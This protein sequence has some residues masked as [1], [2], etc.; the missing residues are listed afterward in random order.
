VLEA[1]AGIRVS[2]GFLAGVRGRAATLLETEFL[3]H[4]RTLLPTAGVLHA[5]ETTGRAAGELAYVHV[6]RTE[7]LTLMHVGE[8]TS[9]DIDAGGVLPEFTGNHGMPDYSAAFPT[10]IRSCANNSSRLVTSNRW[11]IRATWC[12]TVLAEMNNRSPI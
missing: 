12:S 5:D 7:Y 9:E 2:T 10:H 3:P 11:R 8:R 6:S 1:L 4:L